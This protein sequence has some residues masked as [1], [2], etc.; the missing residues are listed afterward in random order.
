MVMETTIDAKDPRAEA[1]IEAYELYLVEIEVDKSSRIKPPAPTEQVTLNG[2]PVFEDD[3][4]KDQK[5]KKKSS[6][7]NQTPLTDFLTEKEKPAI[8]PKKRSSKKKGGR[9]K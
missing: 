5:V 9:K 6:K 2:Q 3:E 4:D 7:G 8:T 1:L